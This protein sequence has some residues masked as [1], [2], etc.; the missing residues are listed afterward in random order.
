MILQHLTDDELH[1]TMI[2]LGQSERELM[3]KT[4]HHLR[5]VE[6]RRLFSKYKKE[7]LFAYAVEFMGYSEA[8][9]NDR[10][11]AMRL[12]RELP[13]IEEKIESG[14][15]NLTNIVKARTV[16][17]HEKKAQRERTKEQKLELL[18]SIERLSTREAIKTLE[19]QSFADIPKKKNE[20]ALDQF[21]PKVQ[22]KLKRLLD[23]RAN[24]DPS[25]TL[26]DLI[27]QMADLSLEKWDPVRKAERVMKRASRKP[28]K[29]VAESDL[30]DRTVEV[31]SKTEECDAPVPV[32]QQV[33][34]RRTR[35]I[36]AATSHGLFAK[37]R[38]HCSNCG[39][40]RAIER[41]HIVSFAIGGSSEFENLQLLCRNCN[42]R[43]AIET[44]GAETMRS[45]LRE[46]HV[47]WAA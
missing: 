4:L 46:P 37:F 32:A 29:A 40:G 14:A 7:S 2:K 22:A 25:L 28:D 41:D 43:K 18:E 16:F 33:K 15:L 26:H 13:M 1:E 10:I 9:A 17:R 27:D 42:Q 19:L 31:D 45:Y 39:T 23:V 3:T 21:A 11:S 24:V 30:R 35:Y 12:M 44:Y 5:E 47:E 6:S 36:K 34:Q 38:G 8:Q 20:V